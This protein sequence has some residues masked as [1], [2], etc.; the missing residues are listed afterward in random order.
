MQALEQ[1]PFD[2]VDI[3]LTKPGS[4][5]QWAVYSFFGASGIAALFL[6]YFSKRYVRGLWALAFVIFHISF[7][8]YY[9]LASG[10]GWVAIEAQWP[11]DDSLEFGGT[12]QINVGECSAAAMC[13]IK[14]FIVPSFRPTDPRIASL[15]S[16][17]TSWH[18]CKCRNYSVWDVHAD[19]FLGMHA[20]R[21]TYQ[22][23]VQMGFVHNGSGVRV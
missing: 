16:R 22:R 14:Q 11:R 1:H 13:L 9:L 5:F 7:I 20:S 12:R 19:L 8:T 21:C 23:P 10:L 15:P 17:P 2:F 18:G 4:S 3:H 6:V